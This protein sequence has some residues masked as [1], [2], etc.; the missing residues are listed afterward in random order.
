MTTGLF[1]YLSVLSVVLGA[2]LG[3]FLNCLAWRKVHGESVWRGRSH[4]ATCGHVLSAAD[5]VP[6]FS[7]LFL[8]GKCRYCGEKISP[9]YMLTELFL[10]LGYLGIFLRY[11]LSVQ[12]LRLMVLSGILLAVGLVDLESYEI[13]DSFLLTAFLWWLATIPLLLWEA[14]ILDSSF[15]IKKEIVQG[16]LGGFVVAGALLALSLLFDK[17]TGKESL[18]GGDIKL[19]FVTGLYL[20]LGGNLLNLILSCV[21]GLIFVAVVKQ[22]RIPFGPAITLSTYLCLLFADQLVDWYLGLL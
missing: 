7:W 5:L 17:I 19:L 15:S 3:S 20:G 2:V 10:G 11:G 4:C 22:R 18:G 9:R 13:P 21:L 6:V 1:A 12:T 14:H 16:A 8:K